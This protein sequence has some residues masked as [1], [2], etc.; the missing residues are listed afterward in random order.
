MHASVSSKPA[1]DDPS[2]LRPDQP[3]F[4]HSQALTVSGIVT[5]FTSLSSAMSSQSGLP[6][7]SRS[8]T[9]NLPI[10]L[11]LISGFKNGL[12]LL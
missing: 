7:G 3:K 4:E 9:Y 12:L 11:D 8:L 2:L 1:I 6:I 5:M 10:L